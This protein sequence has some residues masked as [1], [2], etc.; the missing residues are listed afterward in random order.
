V[1]KVENKNM[2]RPD[3]I[4]IPFI[5]LYP[6]FQNAFE[7][8]IEAT[9]AEK[10]PDHLIENLRKTTEFEERHIWCIEGLS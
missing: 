2:P 8:E 4:C 9:T 5:D 10:N 3:L 7:V 6:D 1:V